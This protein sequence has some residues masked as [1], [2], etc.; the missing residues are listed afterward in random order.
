MR[1]T[2]S[3]EDT[4]GRPVGTTGRPGGGDDG[5]MVTAELAVALPGLVM[6]VSL[7]LSVVG[8]ASDASRASEAARSAARAASIGTDADVVAEQAHELAPAGSAV[9]IWHEGVWVRVEV[10]SPAR[11]WGPLTLP[12]PHVTAAALLEPGVVP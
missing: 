8:V 1:S 11:R 9:R 4:T 7:L 5:G 2:S 6:V 12:N 10:V 3:S